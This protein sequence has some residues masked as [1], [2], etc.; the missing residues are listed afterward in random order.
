MN[1]QKNDLSYESFLRSQQQTESPKKEAEGWSTRGKA[2]SVAR[3]ALGQGAM[4]GFGDEAEALVSS[5]LRGTPYTEERERIRG[6]MREFKGAYPK[7]A[8]AASLAGGVL[9]P[10]PGSAARSLGATALRSAALGGV[11]G[12]GAAEGDVS[13][14]ATSGLLGAATGGVLGTALAAGGRSLAARAQR[15][16]KGAPSE[17]VSMARRAE[18]AGL[19][20]PEAI[21]QKAQAVVADAPSA[22][23]VDVLGE[24][25]V[26]R[27]RAIRSLGGEPGQQVEKA[28]QER[29]AERPDRLMGALR[30]TTGRD[31]EN[32]VQTVEESIQRGKEQSAPLY[33]KFY[34]QAPEEIAEV[35]AVLNTPFGRLV[36]DR[37]RRNAANEKRVFMEPAQPSMETGIVDQFGTPLATEA[38]AAKHYPQSLDDI[39]KAMDDIIY[40]GRFGSVQP[41][42]GGLTPGELRVAKQLRGEF[43]GA[44]DAKF[45]DY[46]KA[47]SAWAGEKAVRDALESGVD[48]ATKRVDP[49]QVAKDVSELDPSEL[50][51]FQRG[52]LDGLSRKIDENRLR[53]SMV[54][55]RAFKDMLTAVFQ[56]DAGNVGKALKAEMDMMGRAQTVLTGSQTFDKAM[57]VAADRAAT[58]ITRLAEAAMSPIR[59]TALGG[60]GALER[61]LVSPR[62]DA[63]R[64]KEVQ[65][66]LRPAKNIGPLISR[67]ERELGVQQKA[68]RLGGRAARAGAVTSGLNMG[69]FVFRRNPENQ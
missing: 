26:R 22:Q 41:G 40:E 17:V 50:G 8:I 37:A 58:P 63:R 48:A 32:M 28:M 7:T 24:P 20:T 4:L 36:A 61:S 11:A 51:Y 33:Q 3:E 42:Q 38:K 27:M 29:L 56:N 43:L 45:A 57:D 59:T 68:A 5:L 31:R 49:R 35:D 47:R 55:T 25:A 60:L 21:R 23:V 67:I 69:D 9:T 2:L 46:A 66:L 54:N 39:K 14:Q 34:E 12:I 65:E 6:E 30:R 62:Y 53:P 18:A 19:K 1:P 10:V 44:V 16:G 52:Y 64:G 13:Q 15:M